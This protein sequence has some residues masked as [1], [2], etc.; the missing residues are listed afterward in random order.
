M[1]NDS[2]SLSLSF[3]LV[4]SGSGRS[5]EYSILVRPIKTALAARRLESYKNKCAL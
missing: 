4:L 1:R 2:L 3:S 5:A